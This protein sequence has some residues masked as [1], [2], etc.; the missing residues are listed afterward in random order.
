MWGWIDYY[1]EAGEKRNKEDSSDKSYNSDSSD[2][3]D[4]SNGYSDESA[5]GLA[6]EYAIVGTNAGSIFI[7]V[8]NPLLPEVLGKLPTARYRS[9][10]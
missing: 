1:G 3:S 9:N 8:T 2:S 7:R 4:E 6:E 5:D 10:A